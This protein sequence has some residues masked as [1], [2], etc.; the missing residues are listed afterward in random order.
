MTTTRTNRT[1]QSSYWG[2]TRDIY[3]EDVL[4]SRW[5]TTWDLLMRWDTIEDTILIIE[6]INTTRWV[7]WVVSTDW[8][9][10][11]AVSDPTR[12]VRTQPTTSRT[13]RPSI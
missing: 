8:G 2:S 5:D 1:N 9:N 13:D 10:R 6:W 7:R 4:L 3:S 11:W 12:W